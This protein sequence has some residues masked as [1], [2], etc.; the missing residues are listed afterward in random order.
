MR[1]RA[2]GHDGYTYTTDC[3]D[4]LLVT[5]LDFEWPV[6]RGEVHLICLEEITLA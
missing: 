2:T 6:P 3:D 1:C 4:L 5:S